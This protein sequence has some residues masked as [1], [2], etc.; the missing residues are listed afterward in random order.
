MRGSGNRAFDTGFAL[1]VAGII[2]A[3]G[4][5]NLSICVLVFPA[6]GLVIVE[7]KGQL[8]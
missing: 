1:D 4:P 7:I 6:L 8:A 3:L 5:V 2:D